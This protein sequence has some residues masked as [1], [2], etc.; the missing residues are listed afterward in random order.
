MTAIHA[1]TTDTQ[2]T[3]NLIDYP[4]RQRSSGLSTERNHETTHALDKINSEIEEMVV[5]GEDDGDFV[6]VGR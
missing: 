4:F 6:W 5:N 3:T 2:L 1:T